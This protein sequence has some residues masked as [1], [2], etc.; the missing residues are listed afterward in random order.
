MTCC[1]ALTQGMMLEY[2]AA[3]ITGE[4]LQQQQQQASLSLETIRNHSIAH[5]VF[6]DCSLL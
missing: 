5:Q 4:N 6:C 3:T 1:W 2:A